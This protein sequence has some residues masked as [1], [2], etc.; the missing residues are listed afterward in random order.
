IEDSITMA[1][2]GSMVKVSGSRIATPLGPP[3]PGSTP[4]KMPSTRPTI[5]S[6]SVFHVSRTAKPCINKP[7][8]S[9][10]RLSWFAHD[11]VSPPPDRVQGHPV[12]VHALVPEG[13]FERSLRHDDVKRDIEGHEHDRCEQERG[14]QRL[15][16]RDPSDQTHEGGDQE[17][18]RHIKP[19]KLRGETKQQRRNEHR[20]DP[21]KLRARDEGFRG[22][23]SRQE[24]GDEA[25]EAGAAEDH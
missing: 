24:G 5:I 21:A 13:R 18:A 6:A 15:P 22:F 12:R 19:E 3:S 25:I 9:M 11:L 20:H 23:L 14:Q 7:K 16:Q 4:T 10:E 8:A 1:E 2:V 17:E